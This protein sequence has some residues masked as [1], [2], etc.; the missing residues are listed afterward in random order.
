MERRRLD[1][2]PRAAAVGITVDP[3]GNPWI[4]NT[5][6]HV[7]HWNGK[8]W[9]SYTGAATDIAVGA[10]A[11]VWIVG[12]NPVGGGNYGIYH[13]NGSGWTPVGSGAVTIAVNPS[14]NPWIINSTH[15]TY[16]S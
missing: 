5:A 15:H 14:G 9:V 3:T 6:H 16:S 4:V 8:S 12:A 1:P 2:R 13:W 10:N 11:A 7:Y